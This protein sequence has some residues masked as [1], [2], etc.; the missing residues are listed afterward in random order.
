MHRNTAT[1]LREQARRAIGAPGPW[2]LALATACAPSARPGLEEGA[3]EAREPFLVEPEAPGAPGAEPG[4]PAPSPEGELDLES[5][6]LARV[7]AECGIR[8]E[9]LRI[10]GRES[11]IWPDS[12]LGCARSGE[13]CLAV[14]TPGHRFRVEAA[15]RSFAVHTDA[16]GRR[17]HLCD[18]PGA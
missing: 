15:G 10:A 12:S 13:A 16:T 5:R 8:L 6:V 3:R 17:I 7:A 9:A 4:A 11:L 18:P 14:E 1:A 2:I